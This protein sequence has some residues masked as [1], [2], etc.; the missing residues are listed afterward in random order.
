MYKIEHSKIASIVTTSE[1]RMYWYFS[2][3]A[4]FIHS[5]AGHLIY[6]T[7]LPYQNLNKTKLV[8]LIQRLL[9]LKGVS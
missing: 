8:N 5:V 7:Y 6:E 9:K 4:I 3:G 1:Y 2:D